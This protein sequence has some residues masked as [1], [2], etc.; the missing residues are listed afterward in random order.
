M[1][2]GRQVASRMA[3]W[4]I[5]RS[6]GPTASDPAV[7]DINQLLRAATPNLGRQVVRARGLRMSEPSAAYSYLAKGCADSG[8]GSSSFR[9]GIGKSNL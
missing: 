3:A 2:T 8:P 5:G 1:V 9:E 4:S 7:P 6:S